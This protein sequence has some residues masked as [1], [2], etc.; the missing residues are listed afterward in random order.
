[1]T[2]RENFKV[3]FLARCIRDGL[4][5][6][7]MAL[8]A[9]EAADKLAGFS[10]LLGP[11]GGG[12]AGL[13]IG[14]QVNAPGLGGGLGAALGTEGGRKVLGGVSGPLLSLALA[15]P[16]IAGG[17]GGYGLARATDVSDDDVQGVKDKELLDTY[18]METNRL[19]RQKAVRDFGRLKALG[20]RYR[21]P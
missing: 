1:M 18:K 17:L 5:P 11:V 15:A 13:G 6:T 7:E 20:S 14:N 4:E 9:K 21:Q 19:H 16:L 12:L 3:A 10:D 8:R 2:P